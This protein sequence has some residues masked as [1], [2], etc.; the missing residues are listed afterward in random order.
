MGER[1]RSDRGDRGVPGRGPDA[2]DAPRP[3]E[4][5]QDVFLASAHGGYEDPN[6]L[7]ASFP[8][9]DPELGAPSQ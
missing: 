9:A 6:F 5:L 3:G 4:P 1:Q 8:S 7:L 2:A